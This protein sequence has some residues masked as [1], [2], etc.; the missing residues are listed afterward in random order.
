MKRQHAIALALG[1]I[2]AFLVSGLD[3][4]YAANGLSG[5]INTVAPQLGTPGGTEAGG[6]AIWLANLFK[7]M[8]NSIALIMVIASGLVM[9]FSQNEEHGTAARRTILGG[10]IAII[11]VNIA[12]PI[13]NA[14]YGGGDAGGISFGEGLYEEIVSIADWIATPAAVIA[15]LMIIVSGIRAVVT[16]G[17]DNGVA[18]LRRT[19]IAVIIGFT[20]VGIRAGIQQSLTD[21]GEPSAFTEVI[22]NAVNAFLGFLGI[23]AVIV[24]VIAGIMMVLNIG[25]DDQYKKARDLILR[26]AIGLIVIIASAAIVNIVFSGNS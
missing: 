10:I 20:I 16:Y 2:V 15:V 12:E 22:V 26:V 19:V 25:N 4:V 18:Q 14:F 7:P 5:V 13:R 21:A 17:S 6:I 1:V 8:I 24:I 9:V 23:I 3:G 11:L